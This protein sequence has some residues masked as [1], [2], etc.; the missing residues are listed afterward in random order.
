M[1]KM[2]KLE[3]VCIFLLVIGGIN[4]GLVGLINLDLIRLLLGHTVGSLVAIAICLAAIY[5][6]YT[7]WTWRKEQKEG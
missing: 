7:F 2:G 5:I 1:F 4:Y 3:W 6:I